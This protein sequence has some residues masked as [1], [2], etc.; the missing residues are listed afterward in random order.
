M[1]HAPPLPPLGACA[2]ILSCT[3]H[4]HP[5]IF[6]VTVAPPPRPSR[7]LQRPHEPQRTLSPTPAAAATTSPGHAPQRRPEWTPSRSRCKSR[8]AAPS[9]VGPC[10]WRCDQVH[11][12]AATTAAPPPAAPPQPLAIPAPPHRLPPTSLPPCTHMLRPQEADAAPA[13]GGAERGR[14]HGGARSHGRGPPNGC[15]RRAVEGQPAR[16]PPSPPCAHPPSSPHLPRSLHLGRPGRPHGRLPQCVRSLAPVALLAFPPAC[17][18]LPHPSPLV[19]RLL[20]KQVDPDVQE[21]V[22]AKYAEHV[23]VLKCGAQHG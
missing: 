23:K 15:G 14:R 3:P 7:A 5:S 13:A 17:F 11:P 8:A 22:L 10:I 1:A 19:P 6:N 16:L 12:A 21:R 20:S 2:L 9:Q 18:P 4:I